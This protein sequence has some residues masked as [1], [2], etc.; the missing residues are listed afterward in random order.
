LAISKDKYDVSVI[1]PSF[2]QGQFIEDCLRS[3]F[4]TKLHPQ[5][6]V[7]DGGSTDNSLN[8]L[9]KWDRHLYYWQHQPDGGQA[10]AINAGMR[11]ATTPYCCWINSDDFY[12]NDGIEKLINTISSSNAA[13][14]YGKVYD[15]FH[16]NKKRK[17]V[18]VEPFNFDRLAVR[19]IISQPGV[20]IR[21][22][23]WE[24]VGGLDENLH[25]ALDYDLWWKLSQVDDGMHFLDDFVAI[26]RVHAETK[27]NLNRQL[28]YRE[29][30]GVVKGYYGRVPLKWYWAQPWSIWI[31][32][33][34]NRFWN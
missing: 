23:S 4:E 7:M 10:A 1:I 8:I 2:N 15:E 13:A 17:A 20:M 27:T 5:V 29:A 31:K 18:W 6:I 34:K 19:C 11:L 21:R 12:L 33:L 22:K 3:V 26:N 24:A 30:M 32:Y 25:M 28:H 16:H 9:K 14:V